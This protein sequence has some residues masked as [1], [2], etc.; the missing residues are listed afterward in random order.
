MG[1]WVGAST[2]SSPVFVFPRFGGNVWLANVPFTFLTQATRKSGG[3]WFQTPTSELRRIIEKLL[4]RLQK[5]KWPCW[6]SSGCDVILSPFWLERL[7]MI[8]VLAGRCC[9]C[10]VNHPLKMA[11]HM[12]CSLDILCQLK[13]RL[14]KSVL[15]WINL[16]NET[17][18]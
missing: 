10:C 2:V 11:H 12:W 18:S 17:I 5:F 3:S 9:W 8:L 1:A 14:H 6:L 7:G 16:Y 15:P 13:M 4:F